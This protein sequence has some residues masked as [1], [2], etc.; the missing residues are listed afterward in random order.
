MPECYK[1][2]SPLFWPIT[3][4][5]EAYLKGDLSPV[6]VLEEAILRAETFNPSLNAYLERLDKQARLQAK[7]AEKYFRGSSKEIPSLCGVPIS[8]KDTFE[9]KGSFTTYGSAFFRENLTKK[10]HDLVRRLRLSGAVFTG[11]TNTPPHSSI[12][13]GLVWFQAY[14]W[15]L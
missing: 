7:K 3:R 1:S 12:V 6:E 14:L 5:K 9:L 13:H 15:T 2:E 8:I 11:K 10:D 4:L